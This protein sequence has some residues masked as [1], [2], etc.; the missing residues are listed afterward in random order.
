MARD[1]RPET[2]APPG[3]PGRPGRGV[4]GRRRRHPGRPGAIDDARVRRVVEA[5]RAFLAELGGGCTLPVGAHAVAAASG[6]RR[7]RATWCSPGWWPVPTAT[8]SC[9]TRPAATTAR[10]LGRA[11]ARYLL[12]DAGGAGLGPWRPA[13][14]TVALVGAGP[15]DPGLLTWR[16]AELLG[17]ADVVVYDR[18]VAR[19]LLDLAPD[20]RPPDRRRQGSRAVGS[21]GRINELLVT[22]GR[23][24]RR[25]VRLE[26]G[27]PV[28]L[29]PR[30]R[31]GGGSA[32]GRHRGEV[33]PGVSSAFA[34]PAAAG[35][36]VTHRH[37][38][39]SVT[40]VTGH[41]GDPLEP[42]VDWDALGRPGRHAGRAD[43]YGCPRRHRRAADGRR[44]QREPR[45]SPSS[46]GAPPNTNR[47]S[48]PTWPTSPR[49]TFR[50]RPP[51]WW[52]RWPAS[53]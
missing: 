10:A 52:A 17:E 38:S 34:A 40:V 19:R 20:G 23:S 43:G 44:P 8:S 27:R 18:L 2:H 39:T 15:G 4:P 26:G 51:S 25:V 32:A 47:W 9:A 24:G 45:R 21:A 16:G 33:V 28:R 29:R 30:R 3:G 35:I 5:E 1:A 22:H 50:R 49:S 31:G 36:P 11:V 13:V 46:T 14:V 6:R 12:D 37:V 42:G 7:R 41:A 53:T 48:A